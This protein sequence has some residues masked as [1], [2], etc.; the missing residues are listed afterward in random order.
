MK[1]NEVVKFGF[2]LF[3][4]TAV[5]TALVAYVFTL[6]DPIIKEQQIQKDNEARQALLTGA[7]DFKEVYKAANGADEKYDPAIKEIYE[8]VDASGNTIG[9]TIKTATKGYG[10]DVE[11]TTGIA[12][13]DKIAGI[14]MGSMSETPGLGAKAALEPFYGQYTDKKTEELKVEKNT[15]TADN[16]IV[17]I[18]GA[19][20]TSNAV[21]K[22]V[23]I[24]IDTYSKLK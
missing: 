24:A 14:R 5:C 3:A 16:S 6:T 17:A 10:G 21:T 23:N 4:I 20:I 9:Y 19:T 18:S 7:K 12:T 15:A 11:V 8:A 22:G 2:I 1:N 13:D